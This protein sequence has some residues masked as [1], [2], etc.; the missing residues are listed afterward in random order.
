MPYLFASSLNVETP[1]LKNAMNSLFAQNRE[2]SACYVKM[3][4]KYT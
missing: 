3:K 4:E 1:N 2:F